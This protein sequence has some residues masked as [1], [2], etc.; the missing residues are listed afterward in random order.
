[1][2]RAH[3]Q[4]ESGTATGSGN[5]ITLVRDA[6][7]DGTPE[8]RSTLVSGLNGPFGVAVVGN[9][10]Y[11]AN[12]DAIVRYPFTPGQTQITVPGV[13]VADLPAGPINHHWTKSL[14]ASPDGSRLY[15]GVGSNSNAMER[16]TRSGDQPRG[17]PRSRPAFVRPL[18]SSSSSSQRLSLSLRVYSFSIFRRS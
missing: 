3:G 4:V 10:L 14:T 11:V 9:D 5:Q 6:N 1:M 13:K 7:G 17:N 2:A 16:G 8:G 15:V 12:T 18:L